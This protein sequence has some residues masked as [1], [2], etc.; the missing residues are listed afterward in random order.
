[1]HGKHIC[2]SKLGFCC[3]ETRLLG[4]VTDRSTLSLRTTCKPALVFAVFRPTWHAVGGVNRDKLVLSRTNG[5]ARTLLRHR[6]HQC[7]GLNWVLQQLHAPGTPY[8][9]MKVPT[10]VMGYALT[11]SSSTSKLISIASHFC[12][13]LN[14]VTRPNVTCAHREH[15]TAQHSTAQ[16]STAQHSTAQQHSTAT[17]HSSTAPQQHG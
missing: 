11:C 8:V 5:T 6:L 15:S 13:S 4:P 3:K 10:C 1:M 16:H 2:C 12:I 17:Q 7:T 9:L 14:S